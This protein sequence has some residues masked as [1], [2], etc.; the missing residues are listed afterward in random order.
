MLLLI[1]SFPMKNSYDHFPKMIN[2][3]AILLKV[4]IPKQENNVT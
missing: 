4:F 3:P 2:L 1:E